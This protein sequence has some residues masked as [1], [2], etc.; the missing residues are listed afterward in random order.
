MS[1]DDFKQSIVKFHDN[2]QISAIDQ[3]KATPPY[4]TPR[5]LAQFA[6]MAYDDC[7]HGDP[8]P[9][10]GWQLLTTASNSGNGYFGTAYWHPEYQQVVIAHRGTDIT[11]VGALVTD[12]LGVVFK[13][14]VNQ[15][16]SAST[17]ANK[18]VSVLQEIEQ[19][20]KVSF[21]LFFTGHSLGGWLAQITNFTAEYLEKKEFIFLKKLKTGDHERPTSSAV[22]IPY[23]D[24]E[25]YHPHTVAFESPG[26]EK[27]LSEMKDTFDVRLRGCSIFPKL[28]DI[29][30]YLSAPNI[31]NTCNRHLGTVYRIFTD[32]SDMTWK[33]KHTP[34][35]NLATHKLDKILEA[36]DPKTGQV[37]KDDQGRLKIQEVVDWPV[38][39]DL[40]GGAEYIEFFE[41]ADHLNNYH[42]DVMAISLYIKPKGYVQLRYQTKVYDECTKCLSVFTVEE[43]EFLQRYCLLRDYQIVLKTKDSCTV[44]KSREAEEEEA[45]QNVPYFELG[46]DRIRCTKVSKLHVLIPYVKRLVRLLPHIKTKYLQPLD[47]YK[48]YQYETLHYVREIRQ[49]ALEINPGTLDL[50]DFLAS[51]ELFWLLRVVDGDAWTELAKVY[52]VL[53]NTPCTQDYSV[54]GNYT[55]LK[56][57]QLLTDNRM[58]NLKALLE[59]IQNPHLLMIACENNQA[60]NDELRD[61]FKEVFSILKEKKIMKIILTAQSEDSTADFLQQIAT[62]TVGEAFIKR[63]EQLT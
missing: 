19:D 38:S 43:R 55:I 26:C 8:K 1:H 35:Y 7:K 5:V 24:E 40:T 39:A 21:E 31:I 11:N 45:E 63:E 28:L 42:P 6:N 27:K 37:C 62:E 48:M 54:V 59:A 18:V 41:W 33:E 58:I 2:K 22:P 3:L 32:L 52:R 61:M 23:E 16:N 47:I 34:L 49:R 13:N 53:Q 14:Y 44:M 50:G 17:F 60:V 51:D 9:P 46:N 20:K 29:T 57:K 10:D 12:L 30:S 15:M 25:G 56:L 36:F 4:P